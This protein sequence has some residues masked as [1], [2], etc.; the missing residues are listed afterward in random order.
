[1]EYLSPVEMEKRKESLKDLAH[2][3]D[4]IMDAQTGPITYKYPKKNSKHYIDVDNVENNVWW[5]W[6]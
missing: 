3:S 1:M 2:Y 5:Q 4:A 6:C